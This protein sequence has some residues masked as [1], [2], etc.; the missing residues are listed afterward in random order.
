MRVCEGRGAHKWGGASEE[1]GSR[2]CEEG[3]V[4]GGSR[5]RVRAWEG[6]CGGRGVCGKGRVREGACA[7]GRGARA[8]EACARE[9]RVGK[10]L[11]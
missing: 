11:C 3:R 8:W 6:W 7:C 1:R 5:V 9:V 10:C 2:V 4:R